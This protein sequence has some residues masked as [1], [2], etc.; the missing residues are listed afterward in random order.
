MNATLPALL[1]CALA[2]T[3]CE[4]EKKSAEAPVS[5]PETSAAPVKAAPAKAATAAP[6][7]LLGKWHMDLSA[8]KSAPDFQGLTTA[9]QAHALMTI[10]TMQ[11]A[12]AAGGKMDVTFGKA[13]RTGSFQYAATAEG[14]ELD[15]KLSDPN[16]ER[17]EVFTGRFEG[18]ALILSGED[19]NAMRLLPGPPAPPTAHK[20]H[21]VKAAP[22]A[23]AP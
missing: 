16:G 18:E 8:Y 14:F 11:V 4:R 5:P 7:K 15:T 17:H 13:G 2:C 21:A 3:A 6:A 19:Q 23:A 10:E 22:D 9:E 12:F 20:T 1:L